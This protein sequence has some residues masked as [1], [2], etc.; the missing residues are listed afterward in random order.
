MNIKWLMTASACALISASIAKAADVMVPLDPTPAAPVIVA[1][2]FSW[3]GFYIGGQIGN[4]SSKTRRNTIG[5]DRPFPVNENFLPKP[6]GFMAGLYAG[7]N[8]DLGNGLILG[9]DTDIVWTDKDDSKIGQASSIAQGQIAYVENMLKNAGIK[10]VNGAIHAGDERVNGFTLKEK[11]SGATRLR[12]GFAADRIMPYLAGGVAY[13]RLQDIM[14]ISVRAKDHGPVIVS[15]NLL[16]ETKT[17]V[18]YAVGAGID[19]A[20][21]NNVIVRAEYRYSDFG[22]KKFMDDIQELGY[23]TNDFRVGVAYKF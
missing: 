8:A 3:T 14:S 18:G 5:N 20:M 16:D 11:W 21:A 2:T 7:S 6:S 1:P 9:V 13:A 19:F 22:K 15:G 10:V 17:L 4:F 23:K 12:I